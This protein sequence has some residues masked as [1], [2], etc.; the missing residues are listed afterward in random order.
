MKTFYFANCMAAFEGGGVRGAAYAGAYEAAVDAGIR[1]SRVAGS[2]AGAVIASL[3]AA[4][5]SPASLKRRMLET[6]FMALTA[7]AAREAAPFKR[8]G[9]PKAASIARL[10][11]SSWISAIEAGGIHSTRGIKDW[12]EKNLRE[13]LAE[14]GKFVPDRLVQ[15]KDLVL[16]LYLVA[17]DVA[18]K[19]PKMWSRETTPDEIRSRWQSKP[20]VRFPYIS[21][22]SQPVHLSW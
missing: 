3:I 9:L 4:G 15:F 16:P 5:A 22:P 12:I 13:A 6:D 19:E 18:Q 21:S 17:A 1:F 10:L 11:G 14:Q 7:L 8:S 2:S 20:H